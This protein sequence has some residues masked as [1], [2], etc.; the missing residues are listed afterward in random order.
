MAKRI[1]IWSPTARAELRAI[2]RETAWQIL[3]AVDR[4]LETGAGDVIK[5]QPPRT[6]FRLR[7]C[8]YRALFRRIDERTIEVLRV[9]HRSEAYK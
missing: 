2:D 8:D 4:Y 9:K 5:L 3:Q 6:E 1:V 7:S